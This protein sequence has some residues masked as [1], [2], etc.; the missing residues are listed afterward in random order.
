[1]FDRNEDWDYATVQQT[2]QLAITVDKLEMQLG[3][4]VQTLDDMKTQSKTLCENA[5]RNTKSFHSRDIPS[6]SGDI[7]MQSRSRDNPVLKDMRP[8]QFNG[9]EKDGNKDTNFTFLQKWQDFHR[10]FPMVFSGIYHFLFTF[11][12]HGYTQLLDL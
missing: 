6:T 3:L 11:I 9:E 7:S 2:N 4:I 8:P 12:S 10:L 1:M 5:Q